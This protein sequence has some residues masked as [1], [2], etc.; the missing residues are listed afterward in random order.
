MRKVYY[1]PNTQ[2]FVTY[3]VH[4]REEIYDPFKIVYIENMTLGLYDFLKG[5]EKKQECSSNGEIAQEL[6]KGLR[7]Y[8]VKNSSLTKVSLIN[9]YEC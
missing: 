5:K 6:L 9:W 8:L 1:E 3:A 7:T 4:E 2:F